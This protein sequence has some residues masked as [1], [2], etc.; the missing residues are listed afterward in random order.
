MFLDRLA[1]NIERLGDKVALHFLTRPEQPITYQLLGQQVEQAMAFLQQLGVRPGDRVALQLPKCPNFIYLHLAIQRLGAISL[2]LNP[3][4]PPAELSYF[5][6]DAE[7]SLFLAAEA[8]RPVITPLLAKLP[9]LDHCLFGWENRPLPPAGAAPLPHPIQPNDT[10]VMIYTSG[11]TGRPKGAEISHAN[12]AANVA[13][14]H[15]AWGW[16]ENDRLLHILPLFHV[17]GLFVALYGAL[18][19]GATTLLLGEFDPQRVLQTLADEHCTLLMA[20]P[21]IYHRLLGVS[22][23]GR[24]NLSDMRL[25]TSGSDRL[26]DE[27][28]IGFQQRFGHTLLERYGMSETGMNLSNPLYGERRMGSVGRP[29][30][31]VEARIADPESDLPLPVNQVGEVQVRGQHVF[32]GYWRQPQKTAAAFTA[33]GWLKTG[34]L[35]LCQPDG[36][37][38][39]KGRSKDLIISG[40]LNI[41]PPE[42]EQVLAGHPDLL[43]WAVIGCPD[44]EWGERVV[45]VVVKRPGR[46]LSAA[47]I[48]A[49][50]QERLAPYKTPR[51]VIFVDDLPR[52]TLG[53]VQ[54]AILRAN[55][56]LS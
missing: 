54:K 29:L 46:E 27:T 30:P 20:V 31:G 15:Q 49:Y 26:P 44:L 55:S 21:T 13:A 19:A 25:F 36:Y 37:Y 10:A 14:L 33:D 11:T 41:Y 3:A 47:E 6:D 5:L 45:A 28:F 35:G 2:P 51:R 42:V 7:V 23:P 16:Q 56:C 50:C 9:A 4:Y 24:Y 40:G 17:H 48:I 53:K 43:A 32:K 1:E 52:N 18:Y 8:S 34:D 12:L 22:D 38:V 39:L